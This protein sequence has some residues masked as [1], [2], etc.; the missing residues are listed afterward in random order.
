[1]PAS[2]PGLTSSSSTPKPRFSAQRICIRSTISAQSC[3]SVPPAPALIVT[4]ASP[5]VVLAGE[6]PLL[7]EL[8]ELRLDGRDAVVELGGELGVLGDELGQALELVDLGL[9]LA[10]GVEALLEPR[11]LGVRP[12]RRGPGRPRSRAPASPARAR[13][14]GAS[15]ALGIDELAQ[16][17]EL[18][19]DLRDALRQ[20][21]GHRVRRHAVQ[22]TIA[23]S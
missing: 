9:E 21:L 5:R 15:S 10:V 14:R 18:L 13:R 12:A 23:A 2:S 19:A 1:M 22:D 8:G 7:L 3:A 17:D 6:Q 20:G 16:A 11:V 4:S